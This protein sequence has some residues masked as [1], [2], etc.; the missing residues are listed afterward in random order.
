MNISA[1]EVKANLIDKMGE[2]L[3]NAFYL[4]D[5]DI[6]YLTFL[7][8]NHLDLYDSGKENINKLN[9]VSANFFYLSQKVFWENI[10]LRLSKLLDK[11][12]TGFGNKKKLNLTLDTLIENIDVEV[13]L[14]ILLENKLKVINTKGSF[15]RDWRNRHIAHSD[16]DLRLK[17]E[18]F[19]AL[20]VSSRA[21]LDDVLQE[22]YEYMNLIRSHFLDGEYTIYT[23]IIGLSGA[24]RLLSFISTH[25]NSK[26]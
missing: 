10:I 26:I 21:K 3:G 4:I 22:I 25:T 19:N 13:N 17:T 1:A 15:C 9:T 24:E 6:I 18:G 23:K 7:W 5:N 20:E 16:F 8:R 14:K 11:R 12:A 2:K